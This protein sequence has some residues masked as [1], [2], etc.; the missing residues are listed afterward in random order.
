MS[1][2]QPLLSINGLVKDYPGVRAVKGVSFEIAANTV[3]CLVGENGAGKSTLI[4]IITGAEQRTEGE[5]LL[6][7]GEYEPR[8]AQEAREAG[9]STLFQESNVVDELS[10]GENLTL[11]A[12]DSRFG[13]LRTTDRTRAA[14]SAL[15]DIEPAIS[16]DAKVRHLS[17]AQKQIVE[18]ARAVAIDAELLI[19]DEPTAAISEREV[20]RLF[21]VIERLQA[22]GVAVLYISHRLDEIFEIGDTVT[23]LRDGEHVET[24]A[25]SEVDGRAELIRLMTGRAVQEEYRPV[26]RRER[27]VVL[28]AAGLTDAKLKHVSFQLHEGEVVGFYGLVGAGKTEIARTLYGASRSAGEV[29]VNGEMMPRS[30]RASLQR[31]V[32]LVP[33]E[34][35]TQGLF[36]MLTIRNNV[37]SMN[38]SKICRRG[39][40]DGRREREVADGFIEDLNIVTDSREKETAKLSGGN[41]QKVVLAKCLFADADVLLLDEPTR[42]VDVGAKAEIYDIIRGLSADGCAVAIFSSELHEILAICDRIFLLYDGEIRAEL[43]NDG[44]LDTQ[45]ILD[46]VTGGSGVGAVEGEVAR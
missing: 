28:E 42:G 33:E 23:V 30:P 32:A 14:I 38:V 7:G 20:A 18:I 29:T 9:I 31:G 10:V 34:R 21:A 41:Q 26:S 11:G 8:S 6:Y 27:P 24:K 12:E 22:S 40:V 13:F 2:N 44:K 1:I 37:S 36:T 3:H 45:H 25:L 43:E 15:A 19:M 35:R 17:V 5:L 39:I 16:P 46:I 4:K